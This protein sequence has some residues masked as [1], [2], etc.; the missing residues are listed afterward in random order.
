MRK[1]G[2]VVV[3]LLFVA[4]GGF[5]QDLEV[6]ELE[7]MSLRSFVSG[8]AARALGA[9]GV[10]GGLFDNELGAALSVIEDTRGPGF[11]DLDANYI[12]GGLGNLSLD[13]VSASAPFFSDFDNPLLFG[14]YRD[15][16][17]PWSYFTGLHIEGTRAVETDRDYQDPPEQHTVDDNGDETI[18]E[19]IR[20]VTE[21]RIVIPEYFL[22]QH[23]FITRL[24]GMNAG[25]ALAI[26]RRNEGMDD[27][28][29]EN[30][31]FELFNRVTIEEEI[32]DDDV[33]DVDTPPSPYLNV[34][35]SYELNTGGLIDLVND[36]GVDRLGRLVID[37]FDATTFDP[38]ADDLDDDDVLGAPPVNAVV[39]DYQPNVFSGV[40]GVPLFLDDTHYFRPSFR[41]SRTDRGFSELYDFTL[42]AGDPDQAT[43]QSGEH[44]L[45]DVTNAFGLQLDYAMLRDPLLGDNERNQLR[46]DASLMAEL[47]TR[48]RS[49]EGTETEFT[50]GVDDFE[51]DGTD[52]LSITSSQQPALNFGVSAGASHSFYFTPIANF[53]FALA[54]SAQLSFASQVPGGARPT[55]IVTDRQE[56][57]G[58]G[59]N[60]ER[61]ETVETIEYAARGRTNTIS[62][63]VQLPIALSGQPEDWLF[64]FTISSVPGFVWTRTAEISYDQERSLSTVE[65]TTTTADDDPE[66][67]V[68]ETRHADRER[69]SEVTNSW[70]IG[71]VHQLGLNTSFGENVDF[72]I[73]LTGTNTILAFNRLVIQATVAY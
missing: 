19:W 6:S 40:I 37:G 27:I 11:S 31:P 38:V 16:D 34:T 39:N 66:T 17:M 58:D 60:I 52:S 33:A 20:D 63:S 23:Q 26:S 41:Y 50:A 68:T 43:R 36:P 70:S 25:L 47:D 44:E 18:Y 69:S 13:R 53:D 57:D 29:M 42:E 30:N 5:T 48:S 61:T 15:G 62:G 49:F 14:L 59:D 2:V 54:P 8:G 71:A 35:N 3:V 24:N 67:E 46:L 4:A 72:D 1:L 21:T 56:L 65:T 51:E 7:I 32:Q 45:T 9:P 64:G 10:T 28:D 73:M 22:T 12:F 55:E